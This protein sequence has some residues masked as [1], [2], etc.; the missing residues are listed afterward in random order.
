MAIT[1]HYRP[2]MCDR[3]AVCGADLTRRA[4]RWWLSNTWTADRNDFKAQEGGI[5]GSY[6]EPC[7]VPATCKS[8]QYML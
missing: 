3:C 6:M 4:S 2:D 1:L 7:G 5:P 8:V